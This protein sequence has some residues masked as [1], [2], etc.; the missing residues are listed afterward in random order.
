MSDSSNRLGSLL[1]RQ[2]AGSPKGAEDRGSTRGLVVSIDKPGSGGDAGGGDPTA[3]SY[4][5]IAGVTVVSPTA[6]SE[7]GAGIQISVTLA[8]EYVRNISV[9][10]TFD[11]ISYT[12]AGPNFVATIKAYTAGQHDLLVQASATATLPPRAALSAQLHTPIVVSLGQPGPSISA[13]A[14]AQI[15]LNPDGVTGLTVTAVSSDSSQ[16]GEHTVWAYPDYGTSVPAD[17]FQLTPKS[18]VA[19]TFEG[20]VPLNGL[21]VGQRTV[22]V[23]ARC[24]R[25]PSV[26]GQTKL[27]VT[28]TDSTPPKVG[29]V[30]PGDGVPMTLGDITKPVH[31]QGT[32]SDKQSAVTGVHWS[33]D[34]KDQ[35]GTLATTADQWNTWSADVLVSEFG[36]HQLYLLA[37]DEAGNQGKLTITLKVRPDFRPT[38]LAER[39]SEQVY[40]ADLLNFA[41]D[42]TGGQIR[43]ASGLR[44]TSNQV[45]TVLRQPVDLIGI[46]QSA[47]AVVAAAAT[48]N[49]LRV[50]VEILRSHATSLG[51]QGEDDYPSYH[52]CAYDAILSGIGTS[53]TELRL[54]RGAAQ[55][56]RQEVATRIGIALSGT[57]SGPRPDQLDALTLD[58]SALSEVSLERLFGLR[59][60]L[61]TDPLS[62]VP[63]ADFTSWRTTTQRG[64]W[65]AE[66]A[67]RQSPVAYSVILDP[68]LVSAEE[69]V[70]S[71]P[72]ASDLANLL[73]ERQAQLQNLAT[74][75]HGLRA[76]G[77]APV[78]E[79][80]SMLALA[81]PSATF[82]QGFDLAAL[83]A[84]AEQGVDIEGALALFGVDLAGFRYLLQLQALTAV[85]GVTISDAEWS[86]ADDVL[87]AALRRRTYPAWRK[88]ETSIVLAPDSFTIAGSGPSMGAYRLDT[89]ARRDWEMVLHTRT[90]QHQE[91][92]DGQAGLVADAERVALPMLRDGLLDKIGALAGLQ[93]SS[94]GDAMT[95]LYNIDVLASGTLTTSR[96]SVATTSVKLLLASIRSGE[97][98]TGSDA[99]DW[100]PEATFDVAWDRVDTYGDWE[101]A[102]L[103]Y[104]FPEAGL[105]PLRWSTGVSTWFGPL[106]EKLQGGGILR[107]ESLNALKEYKTYMTS[108]STWLDSKLTTTGTNF[109]YLP[110]GTRDATN[111]LLLAKY[112]SDAAAK[113][114]DTDK[115]ILREIFWVV[116][117]LIA[118]ALRD[119]G[120]YEAALDWYWLLYPYTAT[121]VTN[122]ARFLPSI[123]HRV[124]EEFAQ[125]APAPTLGGDIWASNLDPFVLT[126]DPQARPYPHL[127]ATLLSLAG[128]LTRFA[129]DQFTSETD[130]SIGQATQLYL[131]AGDLASHA[132][133]VA[134]PP[135]TQTE[136]A[137]QV[138]ELESLQIKIA[139]QLQ[140][141][142]MGR[143]IAGQ[144]R[145]QSHAASDDTVAQPTPYHFKV[146]LARAQQLA[147]QA[148]QV[149][150]QYFSCLEKYD[151]KTLRNS[152]AQDASDLATA[153]LAVHVAQVTSATDSRTAAK[154]Q[155]DKANAAVGSYQAAIAAPSN[156]YEGK[157]LDQYKQMRDNQNLLAGADLAISTGQ[158]ISAAVDGLGSG[159]VG[160]AM[161]IAGDAIKYD[162]SSK[163]NNLQSQMQANQLQASIEDRK[164]QWSIQLAS[165]QSDVTVAASQKAVAFDQLAVARA[166]SDVATKQ[167][168]QAA[169][170][171]TAIKD[172]ATSPA[173]YA[174][175]VQTVGDVYRYFLQHATATAKLAQAQLAFERAEPVGAFVAADYWR[176]P[177]VMVDSKAPAD[178]LG[179]TG[180]ERLL[181]D[182]SKLDTYAF[183]S[184]QRKLN[185]SQTFSL[186]QLLPVEFVDFRRTGALNFMTPMAWFHQDFPGHYLRLIRQVRLSMVALVPPSRGIRATLSSNGISRVTN[187]S[188]F[189]FGDL[190]LRR[191][192]SSVALTSPANATGVFDIDMQ[193]D[194]LLP[195]EGSG[196]ET[197][198]GLSLPKPSNP[199]DYSTIHDVLLT[200]DYT[201]LSDYNY[202]AQV[203]QRLNADRTRGGDRVLILATD[204]PDQWYQLNNPADPT[205][206]RTVSF[207]LRTVDFPPNLDA[208]TATGVTVRL[209]TNGDETLP[210]TVATLG[211][212]AQTGQG[213]TDGSGLAGT[214]RGADWAR[215]LGDPTG[216]WTLSLD[217]EAGAL[218]DSGAVVDVLFDVTWSG[219]APA[220]PS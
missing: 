213:T 48:V 46:P 163:I 118:D 177:A 81:F 54:A 166:E 72:Q 55:D 130:V 137:L 190:T 9:S 194:M 75:L 204:F 140:K 68:D 66:D 8:A 33:L 71:G 43:D 87:V 80:Q 165:A 149:E 121:H 56:A 98:P 159:A 142:R 20:S 91:L 53:S 18:G 170:R 47:S 152:D 16:F 168:S 49:E 50:P 180:G 79:L 216:D 127:R 206:P 155:V 205:Q 44:P 161:S 200:I 122:D 86:D 196:V 45:A 176:P 39:T 114:N 7:P 220:W 51:S 94:V 119:Q 105:D 41:C 128:C 102:T 52:R 104:L 132:C 146:L 133:F 150:A 103:T 197:T 135:K 95:R 13:T 23:I 144:P 131:T 14:P 174:W 219:Q 62:P 74:G 157:L 10:L 60:T 192:P 199:F 217:A 28:G 101:A 83:Q 147:Q 184:D 171:L 65:Q 37:K 88:E 115:K 123:Y 141:V 203:V 188:G 187:R 201:A 183:S 106:I 4:L 25:M 6:I 134:V 193:P 67:T 185:V 110:H 164:Q 211:H 15:A 2:V 26:T 59:S 84:S 124:N 22:T 38:T 108:V 178:M 42:K 90:V 29:V 27:H 63:P 11:G 151:D 77:G 129:D 167:A 73:A 58:G 208:V 1:S 76:G 30:S 107:T 120:Q 82:P 191:D 35:T 100:Q 179:L 17:G 69:I 3:K 173:M 117:M 85:D 182:L 207:S 70:P 186:A 175:L 99:H 160:A 154:A 143:N 93:R 195:F 97:V 125:P 36:D 218:I 40:L 19:N 96:L 181:E 169:A 113:V 64:R 145:V 138:P 148:I 162:L 139:T 210:P 31:V 202:Q 158:A 34:P 32:T 156:E 61:R 5:H 172:Q 24:A 12:A 111:Q 109:D 136:P 112:C 116:P 153:Q 189:R 21:P 215:L 57:S 126:Q 198:W 92:V 89:T 214:R 212:G 78:G 209:L